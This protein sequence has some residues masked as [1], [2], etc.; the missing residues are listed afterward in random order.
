M[1]AI[2][3]KYTSVGLMMGA[4][5]SYAQAP[6]QGAKDLRTIV[7]ALKAMRTY[8]YE[9]ELQAK[10]EDGKYESLKGA[11]AIDQQAKVMCH[12]SD[13][14]E[15]M[16]AA[17][18]YYR[19]EHDKRTVT[20]IDMDKHYNGRGKQQLQD[21][22]F[23]GQLTA[24]ML[25]SVIV[26]N[27]EIQ[28]YSSVGDTTRISLVLKRGTATPIK[29]IELKYIRSQVM[30]VSMTYYVVYPSVSGAKR[31][32]NT[33]VIRC[34]NYKRDVSSSCKDIHTLFSVRDNE[35]KLN[36]YKNYKLY[37]VI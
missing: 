19:A 33:Q 9:Y 20:V 3:K 13:K 34:Y 17:Q 22:F 26:P 24:N 27:A 12:R 29:R 2:I 30:P 25:D 10:F 8:S 15:F 1:R 16:I 6:S 31:S 23:S 32:V 11:V 35:I 5:F 14:F 21:N 4:S 7:D 28:Q 37:A 36:K 18:W